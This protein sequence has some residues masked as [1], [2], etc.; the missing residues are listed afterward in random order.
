MNMIILCCFVVVFFF[1]ALIDVRQWFPNEAVRCTSGI[2]ETTT[3]SH[4]SGCV[5]F[6]NYTRRSSVFGCLQVS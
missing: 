1:V 2:L 6:E 5:V 4:G 3:C